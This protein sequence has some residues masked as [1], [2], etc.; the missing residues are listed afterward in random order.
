[1]RTTLATLCILLVA[2][3]PV[4]SAQDPDPQ[5]SS[6]MKDL[7]KSL[8]ESQPQLEKLKSLAQQ[9]EAWADLEKSISRERVSACMAAFG[10][11]S[12]CEC[13]NENLHWIVRFETYIRVITAPEARPRPAA[14]S[15][16]SQAINSIFRA[17]EQCV[18]R[19][20]GA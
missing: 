12:F 9:A 2:G 3:A 19:R 17:R 5:S 6:E 13:L 4:A 14:E 10:D 15:D 1:M 16:E 20:T 8:A 7:E 11:P 18:A